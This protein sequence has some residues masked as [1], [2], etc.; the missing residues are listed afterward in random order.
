M[1]QHICGRPSRGPTRPHRPTALRPALLAGLAAALAVSSG[2]VTLGTFC[3]E[4]PPVGVP[5]KLAAQWTPGLIETQDS[6]NGGAP[7]RGL[8]G[9]VFLFDDLRNVIPVTCEGDLIV[10]LY[11]DHPLAAGGQPTRLERWVFPDHIL[12]QLIRKDGYG[13]G[14]TLFLPWVKT[15]R[16]D[17]SH[18][19]LLA[20]FTPRGGNALYESSPSIALGQPGSPMMPGLAQAG[21]PKA[22]AAQ[23]A[24]GQ[25]A[26]P[27]SAQPPAPVQ[28]AGYAAMPQQPAPA[29]AWAP[30]RAPAEGNAQPSA[31]MPLP[32]SIPVKGPAQ[33]GAPPPGQPASLPAAPLPV[34][35]PA[36]QAAPQANWIGVAK[37]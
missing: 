12:K 6:V 3:P 28:Q 10:D 7:L 32:V 27:A 18:V 23:P 19:H 1:S 11:D 31:P 30:A 26:I 4:R 22:T 25:A 34:A 17:I 9:R 33:T 29:N 2:C 14:Y 35:T 36:S 24:A 21:G 5:C 37:Q 13:W 20:A 15:Y 8:T 16:P